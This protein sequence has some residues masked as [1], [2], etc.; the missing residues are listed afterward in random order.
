MVLHITYS[1]NFVDAL[2]ARYHYHHH[3]S[4]RETTLQFD[5]LN[6]TSITT[7]T[8]NTTFNNHSDM[9]IQSEETRWSLLVDPTLNSLYTYFIVKLCLKHKHHLE[10]VHIVEINTLI[11]MLTGMLCKVISSHLKQFKIQFD[12]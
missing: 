10:P 1:E 8:M 11:D 6:I 4:K 5:Y 12:P 3:Q 9:V 2:L 7:L